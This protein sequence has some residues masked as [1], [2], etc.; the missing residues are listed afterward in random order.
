MSDE[1]DPRLPAFIR[2][3]IQEIDKTDSEYKL[4]GFELAGVVITK[5]A[6]EK[7]EKLLES[8]V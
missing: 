5:K 6:K 1:V 3:V 2:F 4:K 8:D 7:Y